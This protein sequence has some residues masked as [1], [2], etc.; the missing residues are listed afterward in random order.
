MFM[1]SKRLLYKTIV[2][3][4]MFTS[5]HVVVAKPVDKMERRYAPCAEIGDD[6]LHPGHKMK[7]CQRMVALVEELRSETGQQIQRRVEQHMQKLAHLVKDLRHGGR[8]YPEIK[9][10]P[11]EGPN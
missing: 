8:R 2:V 5:M 4:A 11:K 10:I 6:V 7:K 1:S 3:L 9:R